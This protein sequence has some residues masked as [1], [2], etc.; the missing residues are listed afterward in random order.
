MHEGIIRIFGE[1]IHLKSI[2]INDVIYEI[3]E[4]SNNI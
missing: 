2:E 1:E 4:M 3:I